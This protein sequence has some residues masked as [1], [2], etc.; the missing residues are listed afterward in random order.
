MR[1][2]LYLDPSRILRWHL[3]IA[4][5][6]SEIPSYEVFCAF[7][8]TRRPFPSIFR[9]LL[10]LERLIYGFSENG[11]TD[12]VVAALPFLLPGLN[13]EIDVVINLSGEERV[14]AGRRVLTP[15]F[16]GV[17]SEIGVMTAIAN[18]QDLFVELHDTACPPQILMACPAISDRQ[19]FAAGLDSAL[20][21][22]VPLIMKALRK[23]TG[24]AAPGLSRSRTVM[25]PPGALS[26]VMWASGTVVSKVIRFLD[27][28]ARGGKAWRIGWR[29]DKRTSLLDR[30]EAAFSVLSGDTHSYLADPFP[31]RHQGQDFIFV[32]QYLYSKNRG[33]IA[34]MTADRNG[35]IGSPHIVVEEPYHLSYPLVFEEDGQIW[36]IPESGA[37]KN[38][39]LYRAVAFPYR[40]TR[41]ACLIQ[42]IEAYDITPL[43]DKGGFWFFVSLRH[44]RST[45]WD[46][47]SLYRAESLA[48]AWTPHVAN[49]VLIDARLSRP[50][51]A[52]IRRGGHTLRPVQDCGRG[53]GGALTLCQIDALDESEF[54]QT[55]IGRIRS[56]RFGCHT[57]NYDHQSGLEVIDLFGDLR[58][59]RQVKASYEPFAFP[60]AGQ[61]P[62]APS[63][64]GS[65]VAQ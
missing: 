1:I 49:P 52:C 34:V 20:S 63:P 25:P 9:L 6:L 15:I 10:Q 5:A 47:L 23:E 32:E 7:A 13:G 61:E 12:S 3:W 54:A 2:C 50:G 16:N 26:S 42:G 28:L 64:F 51:G 65:R 31:F 14:P 38:V 41:E 29:F 59:P 56:E 45:S 35:T 60:S 36:M 58:G 22:A 33:C 48:G 17:P 55:P 21:C 4:E 40:W 44:W 39:S 46:C 62:G 43:G 37:A 11:A 19:V 53:Y 24:L 57:Y 30:R 8:A 18:D 27:L